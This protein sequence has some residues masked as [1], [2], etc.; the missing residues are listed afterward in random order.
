MFQ[1]I[2]NPFIF[3]GSLKKKR[4]FE[5]WYYK[6]VTKDELH[7]VALIPGISL[8]QTDSHAF[9]QA[10]LTCNQ[11]G[12]KEMKTRYIRF[13]REDFHF[14]D[15]NRTLT[16]GKNVFTE[17]HIH[18]ELEIDGLTLWG[19]LRLNN[20]TSIQTT[21][22]TPSIMGFFGYFQFMECYHGVISMDHTLDG[23][24]QIGNENISFS[25]GRGYIEKDWGR[26]FPKGYVW[27]QSNHFSDNT[28]SF[29]FSHAVIPFLGMSFKGLI[30][31]L[32]SNHKEY[33]FATYNNAKIKQRSIKANQ[34]H[35][36]IKRGRYRLIVDAINE[37]TIS[38]SSP[39]NG[40][41]NQSIK[42][43]LSGTI[44]LKLYCKNQLILEDIGR[45]SGLEIMMEM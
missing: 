27:M 33:R 42:E 41:M 2:R 30:V 26:S 11:N 22:F 23:E 10:F 36:E 3:Q 24:L 40:L 34:V 16:I 14:D 39:K 29:M 5:G 15:S 13:D 21:L 9:I 18:V 44:E 19:D 1:K 28:T 12:K 37:E 7:S 43:G 45:L 17:N 8:N 31:N 6:M 4:Y 38:L 20:L 32:I 25:E 35:Y